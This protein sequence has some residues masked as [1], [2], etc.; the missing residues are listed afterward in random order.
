MRTSPVELTEFL[1]QYQPAIQSLTH[2]L[3]HVILEEMSPCYEY[4]FKM[5]SKVVLLYAATE[6]VIRDNICAIGVF[7]KHVTLGFR[8][9][10]DL[11]DLGGLLLGSGK[12]W[13]HLRLKNLSE[14]DRPELRGFLRQARKLAGMKRRD[15]RHPGEVVTSVKKQRGH[16]G[17]RHQLPIPSP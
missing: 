13:R 10:K 14:L 6:K 9:G 12:T 16:E 5:R 2:G 15:P 4:I 17:P 8:Q 7:P 1:H 3:R 11:K